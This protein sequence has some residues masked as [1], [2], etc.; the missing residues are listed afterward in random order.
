M[1]YAPSVCLAFEVGS[2]RWQHPTL[3]GW[4]GVQTGGPCAVWTQLSQGQMDTRYLREGCV[5]Y[6][7]PIAR[8]TIFFKNYLGTLYYLV[9]NLAYGFPAMA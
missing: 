3:E 2:R 4:L 7:P 8:S 9:E 6:I 5:L 1:H